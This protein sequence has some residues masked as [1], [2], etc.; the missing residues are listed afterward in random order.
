VKLAT[1]GAAGTTFGFQTMAHEGRGGEATADS[2][3]PT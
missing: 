2:P 1:A 3:P